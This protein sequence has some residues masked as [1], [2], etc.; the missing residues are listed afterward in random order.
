MRALIIE[1]QEAAAKLIAYVIAPLT[2]EVIVRSTMQAALADIG[3]A[4][5]PEIITVDL[6]LPDSTRDFTIRT[7]V[8]QIRLL[9]P[10]ALIIVLSAMVGP[11]EEQDC[12][13]AGAD[14]VYDK[15]QIA[16]QATFMH[17][18][19]QLVLKLSK[20]PR[21]REANL[22]ILETIAQKITELGQQNEPRP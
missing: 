8:P 18:L 1:D 21:E 13:R 15:I 10:D 12:L 6:G 3:S 16:P 22:R 4:R 19:H 9:A 7:R 5:P 11:D 14:A 2:S 20:R 17:N